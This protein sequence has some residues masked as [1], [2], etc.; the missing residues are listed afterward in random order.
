MD[1]AAKLNFVSASQSVTEQPLP[2]GYSLPPS[3]ERHSVTEQ[4]GDDS[5][6]AI[7]EPPEETDEVEQ[8]LKV[9]S[10]NKKSVPPV[11]IELTTLRL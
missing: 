2:I 7:D 10:C 5:N 4:E 1:K 3:S 11:R 6:A 9:N 8:V